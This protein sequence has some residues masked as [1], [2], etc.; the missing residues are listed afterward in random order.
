MGAM[1]I[2]GMIETTEMLGTNRRAVLEWHVLY[3]HYPPPP[4]SV[5]DIA[6]VAIEH[7]MDEELDAVIQFSDFDEK[8]GNKSMRVGDIMEKLHLWEFI[9]AG[10]EEE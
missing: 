6:E 2:L 9:E 4:H 8:F 10:E 1:S 7:A 3:N 5:V